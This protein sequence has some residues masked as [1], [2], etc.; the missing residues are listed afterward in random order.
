MLMHLYIVCLK[1][2]GTYT[3][4]SFSVTVYVTLLFIIYYSTGSAQ[5]A[6]PLLLVSLSLSLSLF[7]LYQPTQGTYG[8]AK[9]FAL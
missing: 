6:R 8:S 5:V 3:Y 4:L 7:F 1:Y 2:S 9:S